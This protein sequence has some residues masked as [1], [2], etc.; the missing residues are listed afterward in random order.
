[1]MGALPGWER[2]G[3]LHSRLERASRVGDAKE[4]GT[5]LRSRPGNL[6]GGTHL[7]GS[8]VSLP[9]TR[10]TEARMSLDSI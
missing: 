1:M 3:L 7:G 4:V 6:G 10:G 5:R 9:W 8:P 2:L